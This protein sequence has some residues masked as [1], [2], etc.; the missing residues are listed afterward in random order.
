LDGVYTSQHDRRVQT[1]GRIQ[2]FHLLVE[3]P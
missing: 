2:L 3:F 1:L